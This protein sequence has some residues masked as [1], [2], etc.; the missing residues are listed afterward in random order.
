MRFTFFLC[1]LKYYDVGIKLY[2]FFLI[3]SSG[4]AKY[5]VYSLKYTF[6]KNYNW[7][8]FATGRLS[9]VYNTTII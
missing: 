5:Y 4:F 1:S 2:Y 3:E 9:G 6:F 8:F 7:I